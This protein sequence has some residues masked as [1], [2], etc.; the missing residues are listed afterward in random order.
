MKI[1]LYDYWRSSASFRVRIALYL[2]KLDFT[3]VPVDLMS[4]EN[5]SEDYLKINPQGLVPSLI[6]DNRILTQSLAIIEYLD[7]T[8]KLSVLPS[9]PDERQR[10]KSLSYAIAME[11]HPICNL[12]VSTYARE[13]SGSKITM[14]QWMEQFIPRGLKAFEQL[15]NH[16]QTGRYCQGDKVTMADICLIPQLYNANRWNIPLA[17]Y[18]R[19]QEIA[20][21]LSRID[22]FTRASPE[23]TK[24][25]SG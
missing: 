14:N 16:P 2:A 6:M 5:F 9:N 24:K 17:D 8:G 15:L 13:A 19:I 3:I 7:A 22:A 21:N 11:I 4:K 18:P 10:V 1:V 23:E 12:A 25:L 20:D